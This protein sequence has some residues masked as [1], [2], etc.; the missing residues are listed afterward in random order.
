MFT[1]TDLEQLQVEHP[2]WQ[3]E[4]VDGSMLVMG[5]SDYESEEIILE[6]ARLLAN[7]VRP[8]RLGRVTGSSAGFILPSL[9]DVQEADKLKRNLRAP[10]VSFV[11]ADRLKKTKRDF[12]EIMPDLMVEVKSKSESPSDTLCERIKTL[13]EKI[14][15]FLQLGSIVGILIDPEKLTLTIYRLN[16]EPIVL[17]DNDKLRLPDLL[18]VWELTV[19]ELWPPVFE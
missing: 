17:Q 8:Q 12:V 9:E 15:L 16:Q 13:Q 19:S 5:P 14:Q 2:E 6:F 3:M 11:R 1:I 18:P 4:L 10:D 7:W